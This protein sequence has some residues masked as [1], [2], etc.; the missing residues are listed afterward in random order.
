MIFIKQNPTPM[1]KSFTH[2]LLTAFLMLTF[3]FSYGQKEV[4]LQINQYLGNAPFT[5][6]DEGTNNLGT[7]F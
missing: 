1:V 4:R 2:P 6:G 7:R 5:I 3:T